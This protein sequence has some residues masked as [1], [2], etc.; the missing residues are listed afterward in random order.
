MD[1]EGLLLA[2]LQ[3]ARLLGKE[4]LC[5]V[6]LRPDPALAPQGDPIRAVALGRTRGNSLLVTASGN[7]T[8]FGSL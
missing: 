1:S 7:Q 2:G 8:R 6:P 3:R 5:S 4:E